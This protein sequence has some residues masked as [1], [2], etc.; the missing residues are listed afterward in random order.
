VEGKF[1]TGKAVASGG[2]EGE[3]EA[4]AEAEAETGSG[5]SDSSS[6]S[7]NVPIVRGGVA[8]VVVGERTGEPFVISESTENR[9]TGRGFPKLSRLNRSGRGGVGLDT[10]GAGARMVGICMCIGFGPGL[11][12]GLEVELGTGT[13]LSVN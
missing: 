10:L 13:G 9:D 2:A 1:R 4:E 6:S 11:G 7:G 12:L 5:S 3:A 8:V